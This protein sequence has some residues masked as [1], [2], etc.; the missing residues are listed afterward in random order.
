MP[1]NVR[2]ISVNLAVICFFVLSIIASFS[3]LSPFVCCKRAIAGAF[4]IYIVSNIAVRLIN[5]ILI[6]A[7]ITE[8]TESSQKTNNKTGR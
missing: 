3:G 8:Q 2:K 7:I 1:L 6:D 4:L 5:M